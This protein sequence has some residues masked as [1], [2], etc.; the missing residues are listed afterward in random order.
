[1][2]FDLTPAGATSASQ[3]LGAVIHHQRSISGDKSPLVIDHNGMPQI[4]MGPT[5]AERVDIAQ[6]LPICMSALGIGRVFIVTVPLDTLAIRAL[7]VLPARLCQRR[8]SSTTHDFGAEHLLGGM[9][10]GPRI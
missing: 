3:G 7:F 10:P 5:H 2:T 9:D 6:W 4:I 8:L 1:M